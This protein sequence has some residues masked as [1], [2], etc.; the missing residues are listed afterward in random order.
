M[1]P[2]KLTLRYPKAARGESLASLQ[3]AQMNHRRQFLLLRQARLGRA[4]CSQSID[5]ALVEVRGGH[6]GRMARQNSSIETI[7]P[8]GTQ[9]VPRTLG[10]NRMTPDAIL[11]GLGKRSIGDL[12]HAE[13]A[14]G[15]TINFKRAPRP[16]PAPVG[17]GDG[18]AVALHLGQRGEQFR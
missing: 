17:A 7:E 16:L 12:K 15:R 2:T 13:R 11:P 18:I 4:T 8:A 9:I 6:F 3:S 14:R 10:H 5:D 1:S